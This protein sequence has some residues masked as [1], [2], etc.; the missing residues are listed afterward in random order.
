MILNN[1]CI[2][3][4]PMY[5]L[6]LTHVVMLYL[7]MNSYELQW[8]AEQFVV[9]H[10]LWN[11]GQHL[12]PCICMSIAGV[13]WQSRVDKALVAGIKINAKRNLEQT[14]EKCL[15][16]PGMIPRKVT[17]PNTCLHYLQW[18]IRRSQLHSCFDN[19]PVNILLSTVLT[20]ALPMNLT[21]TDNYFDRYLAL[22]TTPTATLTMLW[23]IFCLLF[24]QLLW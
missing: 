21:A 1:C 22:K 14:P 16:K 4:S 3:M 9:V 24:W 8:F 13:I 7:N 15:K 2:C 5:D 12:A 11:C 23:Q 6:G 17:V 19:A 20:T 10:G 18:G